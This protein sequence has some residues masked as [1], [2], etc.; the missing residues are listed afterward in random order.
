MFN[1]QPAVK[2]VLFLLVAT[3]LFFINGALAGSL[4]PDRGKMATGDYGLGDVGLF[5]INAAKFLLGLAGSLALLAFV[6]GGVMLLVSGGQNDMTS[7]GRLAITGAAIGLVIVLSSWTAVNFLMRSMGYEGA[8]YTVPA[9]EARPATAVSAPSVYPAGESALR[10]FLLSNYGVDVNNP[11]C[12]PT[13]TTGCTNLEGLRPSTITTVIN[14]AG[15]IGGSNVVITGGTEPGHSTLH[16]NGY[17]VD[18]RLNG[19]ITD[20]VTANATSGPYPRG[21]DTCY[22]VNVTEYCRETDHW[23]VCVNC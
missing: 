10:T 14:L 16:T 1:K 20:Y 23:D 8:W 21:T 5:V 18:L 17:K 9:E 22:M 6:A 12:S 11:P 2:L 19:E 3:F 15:A 4:V 7:K 13:Q